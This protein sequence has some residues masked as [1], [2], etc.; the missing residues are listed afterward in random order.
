MQGTQNVPYIVELDA[1]MNCTCVDFQRNFKP[2][3]HI[4]FIITQVAKD[5]IDKYEHDS[6]IIDE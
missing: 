5:S 2:C 3:K 6:L 4:Y 1:M